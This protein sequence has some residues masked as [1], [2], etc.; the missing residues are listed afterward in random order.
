MSE[1]LQDKDAQ[2]RG[3]RENS[4]TPVFDPGLS[5]LGTDAEAGGAG[6]LPAS[7]QTAGGQPMDTTPEAGGIG[8][9]L[10]P[11]VW[12]ALAAAAVVVVIIAAVMSF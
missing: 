2:W 4:A 9:R 3:R 12:Y 11:K 7:D 6:A 1:S 5:P 10:T 8:A